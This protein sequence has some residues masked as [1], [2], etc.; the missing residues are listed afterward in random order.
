M[1]PKAQHE[2]V[3]KEAEKLKSQICVVEG[4]FKNYEEE[5]QAIARKVIEV[6]KKTSTKLDCITEA[7]IQT[8]I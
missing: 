8:G 1:G 4:E 6:L 7:H 2:L 3:F 5:N